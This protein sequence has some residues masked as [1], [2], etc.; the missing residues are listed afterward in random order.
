MF[1][2]D[3]TPEQ[4]T[5]LVSALEQLVEKGLAHPS[6]AAPIATGL[7]SRAVFLAQEYAVGESL[8]V[9][10]K[11]R[12]SLPPAEATTL[13]ES[14]AAAI[15]AAA[16]VGVTHGSLHPRDIILSGDSARITGF[17]VTAALSSIGAGVP[18]RPPYSAP[19]QA[20]D[21]YSL[22]AIAFE[23]T[24]GRRFSSANLEEVELE[25]GV[26]LR[27]AFSA[28]LALD[29]G[30]RPARAG[31]FA[32]AL[33]H[34]AALAP[35]APPAP[36]EDLIDRFA[37]EP[38][39]QPTPLPASWAEPPPRMFQPGA[40]EVESGGRGRLLP[41][42]LISVVIAGLVLGYLFVAPPKPTP[43]PA[44]TTKPS[45]SETT[46]DVPSSAQPSP[47][48]THVPSAPAEK[49]SL[50][51]PT[52]SRPASGAS[53]KLPARSRRV[54]ALGILMIRSNPANADV[55]VNGLA[56]GKTPISLRDLPL[57]SY[58]I[59]VARD[60]YVSEQRHVQLTAREATAAMGFSLRAASAGSPPA[61][62]ETPAATGAGAINVQS[63]PSGA[64]VFVNDR[65]IGS[66]PLTIPSMPPGAA[67][68]RIEMDGY[69][70]W[71]TTVGVNAG[72]PTRVNASLDRR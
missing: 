30:R 65:L 32:S 15:D 57:G 44:A 39:E 49:P 52:P 8:D 69:Q 9:V 47:P 71:T 7:D 31:H 10:L 66:T 46:V 41:I 58:T 35:A 67:T 23:A 19:D 51:A 40:P 17:G 36:L 6:I 33:R 5:A 37:P 64:R 50:P 3:L 14:L 2:R 11:E 20:S 38:R 70:T 56:R 68:V 63:R 18:D 25:H 60:G 54:A 62:A 27:N 1:R 53:T 22:A 21:L 24:F 29:P 34:A 4:S 42:L 13:I 59:R 45:V 61:P 43:A 48:P 26:E 72:E 12:G 55:T 28:S 16:D